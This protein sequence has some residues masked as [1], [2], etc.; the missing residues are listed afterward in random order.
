MVYIVQVLVEHPTHALDTTFDYLANEE[1]MGGVRVAIAFGYQRIIGYVLGCE[2]SS[3]TK[4]ELEKIAGFKYRYISEII[5]E[6]PLL[7]QELQELSLTLAK[8][9]LSPRI[10]CLQAMLPPQLKPSTNKSVGIKYQKVIKVINKNI[11]VNTV[12]QQEA[13]QF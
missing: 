4:E 13:Y 10:S 5:D 12:K 3:M 7:N 2:Y 1:I 8:L 9:T 6:R 11:V